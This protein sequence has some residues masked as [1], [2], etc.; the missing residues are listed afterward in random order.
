[1]LGRR[2]SD[3]EGAEHGGEMPGLG[4]LSADTVFARQKTQVRT[5]AAVC[6]APF[7]G[8]KLQGYQIHMGCTETDAKPFCILPDGSADGAVSGNVFGTYIHGLFDSGE[9]TAV[10]AD[11][12]LQRKGLES[13][14]AA[15]ETHRD[16]QERQLDLLADTVRQSLDLPAVYRAMEAFDHG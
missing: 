11:W 1:M 16:Y 5:E 15:V 14:P 7:E 12:L 2:L 4:L 10:L 8:A 3:P 9:L 6:A 13:A